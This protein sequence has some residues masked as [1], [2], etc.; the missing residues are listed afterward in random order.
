MDP[1]AALADFLHLGKAP[2]FEWVVANIPDGDFAGVWNRSG[3]TAAMERIAYRIFDRPTFM[4]GALAIA[5]PA[6]RTVR[7]MKIV[8]PALAL[9]EERAHTQP[10]RSGGE[11][12]ELLPYDRALAE[13]LLRPLYLVTRDLLATLMRLAERRG[14]GRLYSLSTVSHALNNFWTTYAAW[15]RWGDER[16]VTGRVHARFAR[17]LRRV[18]PT[19]T[20]A[21]IIGETS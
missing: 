4:A 7:V 20:W 5:R 13:K 6:F 9:V 1:L 16:P 19:P 17:T 11:M 8:R 12:P 15:E 10:G 2:P 21:Q 18:W 14:S 3:D